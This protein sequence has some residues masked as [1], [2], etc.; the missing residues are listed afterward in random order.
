MTVGVGS[1]A[2]DRVCARAREL[3]TL[4]GPDADIRHAL[5]ALGELAA[6]R[7]E[8]AIC[9]DLAGRLVRAPD[10]GSGLIAVA[11]EYLLGAVGYFTG[12]QAD[13]ERRLTAGIERLRTVDRTLLRREVG[14]RPVL[15]CHN[16]RA[17]VRSM[18]GDPAGA[19]ADIA[20][21]EASPRNSTTRT[22]A[23]TRRST[24]PGWRCRN[25]TWQ[26]PTRRAGGAGTSGGTPVCR[27]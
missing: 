11:G 1:D 26:R 10:D 24:R 25:T 13:G 14:R 16:F 3:L 8:F 17:L 12:R 6:N 21:A 20:A 4:V 2:V 5:W 23:P 9:A 19:W 22:A 7:A 27:T 18:R 15:A